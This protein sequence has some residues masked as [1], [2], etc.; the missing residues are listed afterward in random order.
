MYPHIVAMWEK[1]AK[2]MRMD[3]TAYD[4]Q[5]DDIIRAACKQSVAITNVMRF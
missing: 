2:K 1:R 5:F 3:K 4:F